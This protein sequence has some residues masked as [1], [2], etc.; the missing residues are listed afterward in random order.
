MTEQANRDLRART[1]A[2]ALRII[3]VYASL[4]K[5]TEAQAIWK[6][7]AE[8]RHISGDALPRSWPR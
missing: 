6:A 7:N 2:Y 4:P 8:E 5:T 3:R 1:K